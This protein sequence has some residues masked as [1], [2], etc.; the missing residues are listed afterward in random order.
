MWSI[1]TPLLIGRATGG[2]RYIRVVLAIVLM[3]CVIAGVIYA[4]LIF[5]AVRSTPE[6]HHVQHNSSQ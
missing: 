4:A 5:N 6:K 2:W 1:L 3:G